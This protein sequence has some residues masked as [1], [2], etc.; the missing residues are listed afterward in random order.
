MSVHRVRSGEQGDHGIGMRHGDGVAV[1][2]EGLRQTVLLRRNHLHDDRRDR[3]LDRRDRDFVFLGEVVEFLQVIGARVEVHRH[4]RHGGDAFD[5][6]GACGAV[7][8][9]DEGG[10][11]GCDEIR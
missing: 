11:S 2:A 9:S 10:W 3:D 8:E 5:F 1:V 4:R 7:P 6:H